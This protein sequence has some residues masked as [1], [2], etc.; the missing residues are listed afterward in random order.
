[1]EIAKE[2]ERHTPGVQIIQC[3]KD[4][5]RDAQIR[6]KFSSRNQC[7]IGNL[8]YILTINARSFLISAEFWG[9]ESGWLGVIS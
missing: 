7:A 9:L 1:M 3:P 8:F 4:A 6:I 2:W 5:S